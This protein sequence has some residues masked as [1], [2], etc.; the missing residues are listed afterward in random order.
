MNDES[1]LQVTPDLARIILREPRGEPLEKVVFFVAYPWLLHHQLDFAFAHAL[2]A[3]GLEVAV[4]LCNQ[5]QRSSRMPLG[6]EV[7][8]FAEDPEAFCAG[9]H[10]I[11]PGVFQGLLQLPLDAGPAAEDL[12]DRLLPDIS[13]AELAE[14]MDLSVADVPAFRMAYSTLLTRYRVPALDLLEDWRLLLCNEARTVLR[15][16][17]GL[18]QHRL[19]LQERASVTAAFVFNGRFTPYRTAF[20]YFRRLEIDTYMHER[21]GSD[22]DYMIALNRTVTDPLAF[23][24]PAFIS[25]LS[26]LNDQQKQSCI[27]KA[28]EKLGQKALGINTGW[29]SFVRSQ[30]EHKALSFAD[31][32]QPVVCFFTSSPDEVDYVDESISILPRQLRLLA[33]ISEDFQSKNWQSWIRHHPNTSSDGNSLG[34]AVL[35]YLDQAHKFSTSFTHNFMG[36]DPIDSLMLAR[37]ATASV[38]LTSSICLEV[39]YVMKKCIVDVSSW[40]APLFPPRMIVSLNQ[41]GDCF[42]SD[43]FLLACQCEPMTSEEYEFF[44]IKV[45]SIF[46]ANRHVFSSFGYVDTIQLRWDLNETYSRLFDDQLLANVSADLQARRLV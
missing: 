31:N 29:Y 24:D 12:I 9:C 28:S 6:C 26:N 5:V 8:H 7:L 2:K 44:L 35:G 40:Y 20:D 3:R 32:K 18:D 38:A 25:V 4:I 11:Y 30:D 33:S 36:H 23:C 21:G 17:L 42:D 22:G 34:R 41:N 43:E 39:A 16:W 45:Y 46:F 14:V 37:H 19:Y 1:N 15:V 10:Q 13:T 27:A